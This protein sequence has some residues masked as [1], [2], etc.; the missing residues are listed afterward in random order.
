MRQMAFGGGRGWMDEMHECYSAAPSWLGASYTALGS[1]V[2]HGTP[3]LPNPWWVTQAQGLS[4]S[5]STPRVAPYIAWHLK[6][7][8]N[9]GA[10]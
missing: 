4:S 5:Y 8:H 3:V 6:G 2:Y 7:T 1:N 10:D 9:L